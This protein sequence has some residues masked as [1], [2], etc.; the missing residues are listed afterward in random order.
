M[1]KILELANVWF[2]RFFYFK[3]EICI[4]LAVNCTAQDCAIGC[5]LSIGLLNGKF[6]AE[7]YY[8]LGKSREPNIC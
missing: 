4:D 8:K 5:A 3:V 1:F 6:T 7:I 2:S